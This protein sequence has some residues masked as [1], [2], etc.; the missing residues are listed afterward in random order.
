[1]AIELCGAHKYKCGQYKNSYEHKQKQ[2]N[3]LM[4]LWVWAY[5]IYMEI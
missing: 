2:R 5:K 3:P 4:P 1:M